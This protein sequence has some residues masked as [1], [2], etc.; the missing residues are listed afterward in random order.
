VR[1][2]TA[3]EPDRGGDI[4]FVA[5]ELSGCAFPFRGRIEVLGCTGFELGRLH[6]SGYGTVVVSEGSAPWYAFGL[7]GFARLKTSE[8]MTAV[9]GAGFVVPLQDVEF[10]LENVGVVHTASGAIARF[11]LGIDVDF[12]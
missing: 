8:S 12:P 4:D 2:L 3:F 10:T 9:L 11:S 5:A 1:T 7:H 6:G